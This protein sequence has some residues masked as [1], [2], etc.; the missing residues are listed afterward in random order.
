MDFGR[1]QNQEVKK[2]KPHFPP[3]KEGRAKYID[4]NHQI[5]SLI[6]EPITLQENR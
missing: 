2:M 5:L 3:G 1:L 6:I 4:T